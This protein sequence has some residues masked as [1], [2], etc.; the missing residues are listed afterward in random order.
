[1]YDETKKL[2]IILYI[3]DVLD[4]AAG[5]RVGYHGVVVGRRPPLQA[6]LLLPHLRPLSLLQ[7]RRLHLGRQ[8]GP[9][10]LPVVFSTE[11]EFF[12]WPCQF[13]ET[14]RLV[15]ALLRTGHLHLLLSK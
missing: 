5:D 15:V 1:M 14:T 7:H 3:G 11:N 4:D 12:I 6:L 9:R 8:V 13:R 10:Y 2:I